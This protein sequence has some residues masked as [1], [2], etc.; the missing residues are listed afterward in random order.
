MKPALVIQH[1]PLGPPGILAE[2]MAERGIPF[3]VHRADS[4]DAWP[5][6]HDHAFVAVLGSRFSPTDTAEPAVTSTRAYV[7]RAIEDD[8]PVLGLCFGGQL[9][10]HVLGGDVEPVPGGPELGWHTIET[11]DPETVPSGPWLQWHW[12]RFHTPPGADELARSSAGTQAF[13]HGRHLGVQFHPESTIDIVAKWA[14]T[15]ADRLEEHGVD[16]GRALL[17]E[18]RAQ[19]QTAARNARTLFDGFLARA[20][21]GRRE[22]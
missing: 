11:D 12:H 18:G 20:R 19:A 1:G 22:G 7:D 14:E 9:L 13:A 21:N 5:E 17:E 8:V 2:W 6:L 4:G 10:A 16:D 3:A 15:D